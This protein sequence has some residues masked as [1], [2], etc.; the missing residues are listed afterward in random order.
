MRRSGGFSGIWRRRETTGRP[1]QKP[2]IEENNFGVSSG[3]RSSSCRNSTA[4]WLIS[5]EMLFPALYVLSLVSF[6]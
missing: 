5:V 1:F 3:G 2:P 4:E 6:L